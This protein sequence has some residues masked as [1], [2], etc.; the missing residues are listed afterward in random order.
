MQRSTKAPRSVAF[1]AAENISTNMSAN[2][3]L[4]DVIAERLSRR[5]LVQGLLA[6]SASARP[7]RRWPLLAP[8]AAHAEITNTTPAFNFKE[9]EAGVDDKHTSPRAT[10]PT[11]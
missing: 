8:V 5:D 2:P 11:C 1:E 7:F 10:M 9:V 4:G 6:V 3:T